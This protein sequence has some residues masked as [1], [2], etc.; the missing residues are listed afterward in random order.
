[1]WNLLVFY[2]FY[3]VFKVLHS[4]FPGTKKDLST[5]KFRK[6]VA[7]STAGIGDTLT[8][9]PAIRALK[10][11]YPH[12]HLTVVTHRR[13]AEIAKH[14]PFIDELILHKKG[15]L[16]FLKTIFLLKM[17][18]YDLAIVLRANDPDIWPLAWLVNR[19]ALVSCP[20]MTRMDFL[21]SHPVM[22]PEWD[23]T[24]GVE[25]TLDIVRYIGA[26]TKNRRLIYH[27]KDEEMREMEGLLTKL[28]VQNRDL[29]A[30]QV[31]GGTRGNY[32]DWEYRNYIV[33]G[34]RL[35]NEF[36]LTL[37]L[38]GGKDNLRKASLIEDGVRKGILNLTGKL[39]LTQT[40]TLLKRCKVL[41][42]TD[43]GI[44][45]LGF[46]VEG[47]DVIALLHCF[48]PASR[49]GPYWYGDKHTVIQLKPPLGQ[50]PSMGISMD[51]I[52]P[53]VVYKKLSGVCIR[54]EIRRGRRDES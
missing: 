40:A 31:G 1:M 27:V 5:G 52:S 23:H 22:L 42:S 2:S 51:L 48:N 32:R 54:K 26:D 44:M 41:V 38:I 19:H 43:T 6:I 4:I 33:I 17:K 7:F 29:V 25:Q 45:H 3:Y 49:V 18:Q 37:I 20:V 16:Y 15:F 9:S 30:F 24:H 34:K 13:R 53:E 11:S 8:D 28:G 10:E 21:I 50:K 46:A 36:D 47:I 35:L 39:S 14:N 12:A